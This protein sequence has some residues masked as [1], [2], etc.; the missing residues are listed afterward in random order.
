[1]LGCLKNIVGATVVIAVAFYVMFWLSF[2]RWNQ[3]LEVTVDFKGQSFSGYS[4]SSVAKGEKWFSS[5]LP[6]EVRGG[7]SEFSG[8]AV[9][10]ALPDNRYLFALL[11]GEQGVSAEDLA[12]KA[13]AKEISAQGSNNKAGLRFLSTSDA[14]AELPRNA[15]PILVTFDDIS[16]PASVRRVDPDDL[17]ATFGPGYSLKSITLE[18]T[19]EGETSGRVEGLFSYFSWPKSKREAYACEKYRCGRNPIRIQYPNGTKD[20]L[21][22]RDFVRG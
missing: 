2:Y 9:V 6:P 12:L 8:E 22:Q 18:L 7:I 5:W 19:S 1:M 16:G 3:K 10:V 11:K 21:T 17:A 14:K 13:F 4:I 15:Y 20:S